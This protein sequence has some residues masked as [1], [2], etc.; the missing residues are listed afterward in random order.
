MTRF[1]VDPMLCPI[2]ADIPNK[3]AHQE[4][5]ML[6]ALASSNASLDSFVAQQRLHRRDG[7]PSSERD[8]L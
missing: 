7:V 1:S 6:R 4:L 8:S 2:N 5:L 3:I